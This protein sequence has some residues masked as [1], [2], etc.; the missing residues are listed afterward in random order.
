MVY[1]GEV[2]ASDAPTTYYFDISDFAKHLKKTDDIVISFS[3]MEADRDTTV[4]ISNIALY[5][6]SLNGEK[7][8]GVLLIVIISTL[9][10]CAILFVLTKRRGRAMRR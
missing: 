3:A 6:S 2:Y 7:T 4:E 8:L 9:L 10:A 5:G 1:L